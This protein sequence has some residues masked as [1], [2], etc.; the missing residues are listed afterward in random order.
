MAALDIP[1][2]EKSRSML[3]VDLFTEQ[4]LGRMGG[5]A[6]SAQ[7]RHGN[8]G[9]VAQ[10]HGCDAPLSAFVAPAGAGGRI[11]PQ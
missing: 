8:D 3:A 10:S 4:R 11:Q 9:V 7:R 6:P 5:C 2:S 1:D